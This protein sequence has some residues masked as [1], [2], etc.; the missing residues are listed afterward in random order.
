MVEYLA[1]RKVEHL[2]GKK[3]G[4]SV[5]KMEDL[6]EKTVEK[7]YLLILLGRGLNELEVLLL[8]WQELPLAG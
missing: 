5:E 8:S 4:H 3:V 6:A 7:A 2:L 1:E